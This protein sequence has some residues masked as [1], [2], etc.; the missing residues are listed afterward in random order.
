MNLHFPTNVPV[1]IILHVKFNLLLLVD[2]TIHSFIFFVIYPMFQ[3]KSAL[4]TTFN[5]PYRHVTVCRFH[6]NRRFLF[7]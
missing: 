4:Y 1:V 3:L 6:L 2:I 5:L 7:K